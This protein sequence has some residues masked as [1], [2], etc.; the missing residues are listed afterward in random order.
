MAKS[1]Y[2][3]S[4]FGEAVHPWLNKP[5]TKYKNEF[6]VDLRLR[7]PE[8]EALADKL[9]ADAEVA[10]EEQLQKM[11]DE[12]K[13]TPAASK[14]WTTYVPFTREE[15][16]N[17]GEPTGDILFHF[18]Q[19]AEIKIR[20]TGE[21]KQ[22]KIGLYDS[23]G[24]PMSEAIYGGSKLRVRY[25]PRAIAVASAQQAGIRLDFSMV[26]VL[27][28]KQGSGG[29]GFGK[30]EGGFVSSDQKPDPEPASADQDPGY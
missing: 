28:L 22:V 20:N 4:P 14:K 9:Q 29:G 5:D 7:G 12:G 11:R 8:A 17:T 1:V 25:A 3:D 13:L 6:S 18:K 23:E 24:A 2:R 15:D 10:K 16:P 19:N 30:V 27:E 21:V 26:Q